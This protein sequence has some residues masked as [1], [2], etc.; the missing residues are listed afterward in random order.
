MGF[1]IVTRGVR[2]IIFSRETRISYVYDNFD[3]GPIMLPGGAEPK[4]NVAAPKKRPPPKRKGQEQPG[5][6]QKTSQKE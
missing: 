5:P 2:E 3:D 4:M 1:K 6:A